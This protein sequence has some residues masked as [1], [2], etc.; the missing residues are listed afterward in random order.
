MNDILDKEYELSFENQINLKDTIESGQTFLW[1][2]KDG[3]IFNGEEDVY[4]TCRL[5]EDQ[6]VGIEIEQISEDTVVVRTNRDEGY[7]MVSKILGK[8]SYDISEVKSQ[9]LE[10]DADH[11]IMNQAIQS[12]P[13]L[14][15]VQ[16][17]LFPTLISFICSTQMRV[18]RIHK[19]T[20]NISKKYG[21]SLNLPD[22]EIYTFP[23]P[24]ELKQATEKK[25]KN[26]GLGYRARYVEESAE[27]YYQNPPKLSSKNS[28]ARDQIQDFMGVGVKVADCTLLY[29]DSRL[30]VVPVDTWIESAVHQNYPEIQGDSREETA[31]NF[32]RFFGDYSGFAQAYLFHYM[33]TEN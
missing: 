17:P 3:E 26:I 31:R 20:Q 23:T 7:R 4:R 13:G 1:N 21:R 14:R 28:E 22:G 8:D 33:R 32:E 5:Y 10:K 15:I 12:N 30:D 24:N 25:L 11:G 29:G 9:I 19:M 2:A 6:P 27:M 16:E 18:Q